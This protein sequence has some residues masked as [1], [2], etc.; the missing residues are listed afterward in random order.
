[1]NPPMKIPRLALIFFSVVLA[2]CITPEAQRERRIAENIE[3]FYEFPDEVREAIR[4]GEV[5]IGFDE[6]M[7]R[8]ALGSPDRVSRRK[9]VDEDLANWQY[10]RL[11]T[12]LEWVRMPVPYTDEKGRSRVRDESFL[13]DREYKDLELKMEVDFSKGKVVAFETISSN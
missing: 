13:V 10:F 8:L 4:R 7:V 2:G 11:V 5:E 9:D 1:M 3:L 12:E 6:D